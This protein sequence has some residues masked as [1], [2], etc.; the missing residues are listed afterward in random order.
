MK[1]EGRTI[2]TCSVMAI[3]KN[4][5]STNAPF[6][7]ELAKASQRADA[8]LGQVTSRLRYCLKMDR[9]WTVMLRKAREGF[10]GATDLTLVLIREQ[11]YGPRRAHRIAGTMIRF[12]RERGLNATQV[13]GQ[14]LDEAAESLGEKKP[15]L[16]TEEILEALNPVSSVMERHTNIGDPNPKETK[17]LI[18]VRR[19]QLEQL[20]ARQTA[21]RECIKKSLDKLDAE[22]AAILGQHEL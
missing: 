15:G 7:P 1:P 14:L 4:R 21:R 19:A 17:R 6:D 8:A 5:V 11:G 9:A 18:E 20:R 2:N 13:T 16:S 12:A 3:L 10:C 22:I